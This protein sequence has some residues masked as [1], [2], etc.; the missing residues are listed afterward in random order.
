MSTSVFQMAD[1]G[2]RVNESLVHQ[3]EIEVYEA[4]LQLEGLNGQLKTELSTSTELKVNYQCCKVVC[5]V[6]LH[7]KS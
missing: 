7:R 5:T 4:K 2:C 6:S 1:L 3:L